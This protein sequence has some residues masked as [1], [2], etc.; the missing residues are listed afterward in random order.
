MVSKDNQ[1][2]ILK[3][4]TEFSTRIKSEHGWEKDLDEGIE[5]KYCGTYMSIQPSGKYYMAFT[6]NQTEQDVELDEMFWDMV[7][8]LI[9]A[10][11]FESGEGDPCDVYA[12]R[13]IKKK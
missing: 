12:Y 10:I 1:E 9:P 11:W 13:H 4:A 3:E 5:C 6:S 8:A 2:S 7:E